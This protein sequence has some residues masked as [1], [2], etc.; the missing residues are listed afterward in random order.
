M[1]SVVAF[2]QAL[3]YG[4]AQV[5]T[6]EF[7]E[8]MKNKG[9]LLK[10]VIGENADVKFIDEIR[11]LNL[12]YRI[13]PCYNR[14]GF[15]IMDVDG[16]SNWIKHADLIWIT[17][18][19]YLVASRVKKIRRIPVIAHLHSYPLLCPWWGLLYG[20]REICYKGCSIRR[21]V[22]CKQLF[23][24][25]LTR[26]GVIGALTNTVYQ[27]LDFVK[28]PMDYFKWR[29]LVNKKEVV[30]SIDGYIAVS[31]F[32]KKVHQELLSIE[33]KPIEVVYNP[34]TYPFKYVKDI[35]PL[36]DQEEGLIVYASG[37]NPV[38]GPQVLLDALKLLLSEGF[39]VKLIMFNCKGSWVEKYA[40]RLGVEKAVIFTEKVSFSELYRKISTANVAVM[41]SL[42]PE[43][44][45]RVP[46]EANRLGVPSVTS[47]RG[48]LPEMVSTGETNVL[49][50]P[51]AE[52]IADA[53]LKALKIKRGPHITEKSLQICSPEE[54][55]N[56]LVKVFMSY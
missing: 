14:L 4:G 33:D 13:V 40:R 6:V 53:I 20:M 34:V 25:E 48:G 16:V 24:E 47:N 7:F 10:V 39:N 23:N 27:V 22:R 19:E 43:P 3:S 28:G 21:I 17:D 30:D 35:E 18:V 8:C 52:E 54:S 42:W 37:S 1:L 45:G 5:S 29:V 2:S 26:L 32:V 51:S 38:K 31:N 15:P 44:F 50:D 46:V 56:R 36:E 49:V 55:V 11:S 41:P 9:I 12:E